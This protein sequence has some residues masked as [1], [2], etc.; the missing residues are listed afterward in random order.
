MDHWFPA[1]MINFWLASARTWLFLTRSS[2]NLISM[3]KCGQWQTP[4]DDVMMTSSLTSRLIDY[5]RNLETVM[6]TGIFDPFRVE[7]GRIW[8]HTSRKRIISAVRRAWPHVKIPTRTEVIAQNVTLF[9]LLVHFW[10]LSLITSSIYIR[11][12]PNLVGL[13]TYH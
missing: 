11:T 4:F 5:G 2:P 13:L 12:S 6:F 9:A 1:K 10:L 8:P 7:I 3:I